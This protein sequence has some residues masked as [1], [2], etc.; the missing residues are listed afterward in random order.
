MSELFVGMTDNE[1]RLIG[2]RQEVR[3]LSLFNSIT[4]VMNVQNSGLI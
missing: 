4:S 1:M 2:H 3:Q